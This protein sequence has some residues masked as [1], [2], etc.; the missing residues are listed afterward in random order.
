MSSSFRFT[1]DKYLVRGSV[2]VVYLSR[3]FGFFLD[4]FSL[5][6]YLLR[7]VFDG[8]RKRLPASL[9]GDCCF[10]IFRRGSKESTD[11]TSEDDV[12]LPA[13]LWRF[14]ELLACVMARRLSRIAITWSE[15]EVL[16]FRALPRFRFGFTSSLESP[17]L[18]TIAEG[19]FT[20]S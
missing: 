6:E 3:Y 16:R 10:R 14:L 19:M 2:I 4:K 12:E 7:L 8:V 20:I 18:D 5:S 17:C 15:I 9:L 11:S 1:S 13:R